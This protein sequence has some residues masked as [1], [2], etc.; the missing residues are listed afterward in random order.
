MT[1]Q[2]YRAEVRKLGYTPVKPSYEGA[3]LHV[4]R[5]GMHTTIPDPETLEPVE[6]EAFIELLKARAALS[7]H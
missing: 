1:P 6:R 4:G 3:T 7:S 2:A 5:D